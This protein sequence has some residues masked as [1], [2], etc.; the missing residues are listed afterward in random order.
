MSIE[1]DGTDLRLLALLQRT[2]KASL[3]ELSEAAGLSQS[4]CWRRIRRME[5]AGV[6]RGYVARLDPKALGLNAL[7]YLF[8]SL[9]DHRAETIAAFARL[10]EREARIVE[11]ASVT[12]ES[13]YVLK[14]AARDPE[15]LERFLMQ[16]VL[17]SGLVRGSQTHFVLRQT[18][19]RSPWPL[20][21]G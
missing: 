2:G 12:G 18:K 8:V 9:V 21:P 13:D 1:L 14:V 16:D 6:I 20:L 19:S 5:E 4:P 11:C 7:S 15:D 3:Q 10:V 17:A